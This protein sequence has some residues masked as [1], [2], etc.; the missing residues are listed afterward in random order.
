[1]PKLTLPGEQPTVDFDDFTF[2]EVGFNHNIAKDIVIMFMAYINQDD[3]QWTTEFDKN[4]SWETTIGSGGSGMA[5]SCMTKSHQYAIIASAFASYADR[6]Y[7]HLYLGLPEY[8]IFKNLLEE[9]DGNTWGYSHYRQKHDLM[10]K[11]IQ[12]LKTIISEFEQAYLK[13]EPGFLFNIIKNEHA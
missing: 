8:Y 3:L 12:I 11:Q 6:T 4:N 7:S 10:S 2:P 9:I 13:H 5:M 1:M